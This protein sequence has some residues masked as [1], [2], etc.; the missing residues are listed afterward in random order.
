MRLPVR[1]RSL[2]GVPLGR[3][4]IGITGARPF[5][6]GDCQRGER[7]LQAAAYVAWGGERRSTWDDVWRA[8]AGARQVNRMQHDKRLEAR[9]SAAASAGGRVLACIAGVEEYKDTVAA[10]QAL[11]HATRNA[12]HLL[13]SSIPTTPGPHPAGPVGLRRLRSGV[14]LHRVPP[15]Q[16]RGAGRGG[17][18]RQQGAWQHQQYH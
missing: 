2:G 8:V 12:P 10:V 4:C 15:L 14:H 5:C 18:Q 3:C 1:G 7:I 11:V 16:A 13:S 9:G 17:H 6:V